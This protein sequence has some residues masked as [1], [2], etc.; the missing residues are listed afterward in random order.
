MTIDTV[1]FVGL[2]AILAAVAAYS[3]LVVVPRTM[4]S[5]DRYRLWELRDRLVRDIIDGRVESSPAAWQLVRDAEVRIAI[6]PKF[7]LARMLITGRALRGL[8]LPE[9]VRDKP[10]PHGDV[11]ALRAYREE[12]LRINATALITNS[13]VGWTGFLIAIVAAL[14]KVVGRGQATKRLEGRIQRVGTEI[15]REPELARLPVTRD[16]PIPAF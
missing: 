1:Q 8:E 12:L 14:G 13:V 9:W 7:T 2:M 11:E 3:V 10:V 4:V 16:C 6:A 5:L 15:A